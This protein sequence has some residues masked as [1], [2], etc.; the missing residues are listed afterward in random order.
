MKRLFTIVLALI[1]LLTFTSCGY[2]ES[3][4]TTDLTEH[5]VIETTVQTKPTE[6]ETEPIE[7]TVQT[8]PTE[9]TET[10]TEP[11]P[12]PPVITEPVIAIETTPDKSADDYAYPG[13]IGRLCVPYA[14]IDVALYSGIDQGI[15]D[16]QDSANIFRWNDEYGEVIADHNNQEFANLFN[17]Q[18]GTC[19]YIELQDGGL[20]SIECVDV[21]DGCNTGYDLT[22]GDG[23]SVMGQSD[24][25]MY[26]CRSGWENVRICLWN[27]AS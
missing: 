5:V 4:E 27:N 10:E 7:T 16:R 21:I 3:V 6:P 13:F 20:I 9:P 26:T 25:I 17:V 24:Y 11:E 12:E 19:G 15:T 8:E 14:N 23:Y 18:I 22:D 1:L 2:S